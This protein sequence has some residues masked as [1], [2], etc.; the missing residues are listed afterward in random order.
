MRHH[1]ADIYECGPMYILE[2]VSLVV[3]V[4]PMHSF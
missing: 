3:N 2:I 1:T 4:K